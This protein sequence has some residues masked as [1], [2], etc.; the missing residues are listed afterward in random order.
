VKRLI[1][2]GVLVSLAA[3]VGAW[4]ADT[5][6]AGLTEQAALA[7]KVNDRLR[8]LHGRAAGWLEPLAVVPERAP[9]L[10]EKLA[11]VQPTSGVVP[12]RRGR[13]SALA[14]LVAGAVLEGIPGA[15]ER[16][17]FYDPVHRRGLTGR[18]SDEPLSVRLLG[19][20]AGD[21]LP[22]SG[23]PA[24]DWIVD[25]ENDLNL[26]RFWLEL[27]GSVTAE[28]PAARD[29]HLAMALV[30]AGA[31][32][33]VLE[34][35]GAPARARDDLAEHLLPLGASRTDRGSR[36][37]RLAALL[38]GR[39]GVPAPRAAAARARPRDFFTAE[40][41][42]GLADVT[43]RRWYS[44][45]TLPRAVLAPADPARGDVQKRVAGA[46]VYAQPAPRAD[47]KLGPPPGP[48]GHALRDEAGVCLAN[49][50]VIDGKLTF[51]ISDACAAEQL[52]VILPEVAGHARAYLDWLFRGALTVSIMSGSAQVAV[53]EGE[54]GP[55]KG[56]L[57]VLAEDAEGRRRVLSVS[58]WGG[59][60]AT[61]TAATAV[62]VPEG[63]K[64]VVAVVR[65]VDAAGEEM[66]AVGMSSS[67]GGG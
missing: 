53:A 19:K 26:P 50:R 6:H 37:E 40:D 22:G 67:P 21:G 12:D 31:M 30:C 35:M 59:E 49:H 18:S 65:G 46:Q 63:T 16:H 13:Q 23:K 66:V 56:K 36:F 11:A 2:V 32:L 29:E 47:V 5:T 33:H 24:P 58:D 54:A 62:V 17:H 60:A 43:N 7:S 3:P 57:T 41:G 14:W 25:K 20:L 42:A 48:D 38:Y 45:G 8:D 52:A 44:S 55:A 51:A 64:R 28:T 15:R 9:K 10:H 34:D 61:T 39:L 4:E 27:E 1:G